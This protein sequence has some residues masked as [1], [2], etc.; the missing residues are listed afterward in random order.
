[1]RDFELARRHYVHTFNTTTAVTKTNDT[2]GIKVKL[3]GNV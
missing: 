3:L 1:M 2:K